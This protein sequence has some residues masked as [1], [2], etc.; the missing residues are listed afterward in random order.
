MWPVILRELR[1]GSRRWTTYW[2]RLLGAS[3][4]VIAI[5]FWLTEDSSSR[6]AGSDLFAVMH[7]IVFGGIWVLAPLHVWLVMF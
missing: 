7:R 3:A 2:L 1:A 5:F 4:V 6:R